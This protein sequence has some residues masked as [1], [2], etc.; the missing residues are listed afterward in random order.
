MGH[1]GRPIRRLALAEIVAVAVLAVGLVTGRSA[2]ATTRLLDRS[3]SRFDVL[4][5]HR[6]EPLDTAG[7]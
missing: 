6:P 4:V 7:G 1:S 2:S 3:D 5:Q